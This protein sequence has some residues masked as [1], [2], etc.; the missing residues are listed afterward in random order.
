MPAE[1]EILSFGDFSDQSN[2]LVLLSRLDGL[3][4]HCKLASIVLDPRLSFFKLSDDGG[5][6]SWFPRSVLSSSRVQS[7]SSSSS[8]DQLFSSLSTGSLS[9]SS[10]PRLS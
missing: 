9:H 3:Q 8:K 6:D 10:L 5:D 2:R 7:S 1:E 4:Q